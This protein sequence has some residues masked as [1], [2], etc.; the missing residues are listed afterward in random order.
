MCRLVATTF[1]DVSNEDTAKIIHLALIASQAED[2]ANKSGWGVATQNGAFVKDSGSYIAS[3]LEWIDL[4]LG[5]KQ[6]ISPA[7]AHLRNSSA[8]TSVTAKEAQ[9]F[10]YDHFIGMH[11]GKFDGSYNGWRSWKTGDPNSDT[12]RA[13]SRL[14]E[15]LQ[16]H[17]GKMDAGLMTRW[18]NVYDDTSAY[19]LVFIIDGKIMVI[20][21]ASRDLYRI[22]VGNGFLITTS[23]NASKFVQ[24]CA[25]LFD[26]RV[27]FG[28]EAYL[29]LPD[30]LYQITPG[31]QE[32]T[33]EELKLNMRKGTRVWTNTGSNFRSSYGW[34]EE[35]EIDETT[36]GP[37]NVST[38]VPT[39][40]DEEI[41]QVQLGGGAVLLR[42]R[43][44]QISWNDDETKM[45][46]GEE[47][48]ELVQEE[49]LWK[50]LYAHGRERLTTAPVQLVDTLNKE[51]REEIIFG[52]RAAMNPMRET[53]LAMYIDMFNAN[54]IGQELLDDSGV[55]SL[56][57]S[58]KSI[59]D[60]KLQIFWQHLSKNA[61]LHPTDRQSRYILNQWNHKVDAASEKRAVELY[62]GNVLPF[63]V[64]VELAASIINYI[65]ANLSAF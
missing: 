64:S 58:I 47:T 65:P 17:S 48:D 21:N 19:A 31:K 16:D 39:A 43:Q 53:M 62:F 49:I 55:S 52:I 20:R 32:I 2:S 63:M 5:E 12:W 56:H 1:T 40:G 9:P 38:T 7:L 45:S 46:G 57:T 59:T 44:R 6:M 8:G 37:I 42:P 3:G 60:E 28:D 24:R 50:E 33:S 15:M 34:G 11:N 4:L 13:F 41:E 61:A 30:K 36:K 18:L 26:M 29:F 27:S 35:D 51:S 10:V 23:L 14:N 54:L 22:R 25:A